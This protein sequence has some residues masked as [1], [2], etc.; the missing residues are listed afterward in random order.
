MAVILIDQLA[1]D[2]Q[3]RKKARQLLSDIESKAD[4]LHAARPQS[5][6]PTHA[7]RAD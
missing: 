6:V 3:P 2:F 4:L 7:G 1:A 5:G